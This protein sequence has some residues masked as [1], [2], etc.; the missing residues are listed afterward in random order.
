LLATTTFTNETASGWQQANFT[1]PVPINSS[2]IYV[3]STTP[4]PD[5]EPQV[6]FS[7]HGTIRLCTRLSGGSGEWRLRLR[8]EQQFQPNL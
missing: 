7:Y 5:T 6:T 1:T 2:T 4:T 8:W 3:A